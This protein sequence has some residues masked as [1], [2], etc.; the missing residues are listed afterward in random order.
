MKRIRITHLSENQRA[1]AAAMAHGGCEPEYPGVTRRTGNDRLPLSFPQERLWFLDQFQ[2]GVPV[3]NIV[4]Q[5]P[6]PGEPDSAAL[7]TSLRE[8]LRRHEALRTTF[9]VV[10]D[11][12]CQ[13]IRPVEDPCIAVD[14]LR[15]SPEHRRAA[16][17]QSLVDNEL[18]TP[19]DLERGPLYRLRLVRRSPARSL[20][21]V[22]VHHI[23]ADG[24]SV[25][26]FRRELEELYPL[27][28]SGRPSTLPELPA[29]YADFAL[30]Q[31][32]W[33][34]G[35]RLEKLLD[36]WRNQ[37]VGIPPLLGLP[38][39]FPRSNQQNFEGAA[40]SFVIPAPSVA[41]LED[42]ARSRR[43]TLF[44]ALLAVFD[45]LLYHYT[46]QD[47]VAV[48]TP[49]A[50]RP[51]REL[52][53]LIGFFAN[54]LVL[55]TRLDPR[56]PFLALI[57]RVRE[58]TLG[59]YAHQDLPFERVVEELQPE[60]RLSHNPLFQVMFVLQ[61]LPDLPVADGEPEQRAESSAPARSLAKFDLS[62]FLKSGADGLHGVVEYRTDLF[63]HERIA[64]LIEHFRRLIGRLT[65]RP[66]ARVADIDFLGPA[67]R[68]QLRGFQTLDEQRCEPCRGVEAMFAEQAA[69][70]LDAVAVEDADGGWSYRELAER[71]GRLASQLRSL[72]VGPESRVGVSVP[73]G[74]E[75]AVALLGILRAGGAYVPL[76]P[77]FPPERLALM[78]RDAGVA[79]HLTTTILRGSLPATPATVICLDV[80][81]SG[82]ALAVPPVPP[83]PDQLAYVIFTS[84][85]T[86][87]PKG[88]AVTHRVVSRLIA[89]QQRASAAAPGART[90]QF[91]HLGFDVSL[92]EM[93]ATLCTGG[94]LVFPGEETRR[95]MSALWE[96]IVD[97]RIE[98]LFT[99]PLV[100][101]ELAS[102][103]ATSSAGAPSLREI[104]AAGEALRITEPVRALARP[105]RLS[106][107]VNQYGPSETHVAT[108][109]ALSGDP[110]SWPDLPP[111]GKPIDG[112]RAYV[113]TPHG[114][115]SPIGIPG[116]LYL[117][118]ECV[119]RGYVDNP[120]ATAERFLPDPFGPPGTR[121]YRTGDVA[122]WR[123]DGALELFGRCDD[124][125]KIRGFRVEPGEV[126]AALRS[127]PQVRECAV[128]AAR[129]PSGD[130]FL[131]AY[132]VP[133]GEAPTTQ[134]LRRYLARRLPEYLLPS[135]TVV[136]DS[137]PRTPSGKVD[138]RRLP[139]P[140]RLQAARSETAHVPP[141]TPLECALA[142]IWSEVLQRDRVG[143][144][145]NFFDLGGHSLR[146]TQVVARVNSRLGLRMVVS[147]LFEAATVA[148]LAERL[149]PRAEPSEGLG[150]LDSA[151]RCRGHTAGGSS[152]E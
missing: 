51:R 46:G 83:H 16:A 40:Q 135:V 62:M 67:E 117:G 4:W 152:A 137:L 38:T 54:T 112:A 144:H 32:D 27:F 21:L 50:N 82:G 131:V 13:E 56:E 33:L 22:T 65:E 91:A 120:A 49:I 113:L 26:V 96:F 42:L 89:W 23:V 95:D 110:G 45:A 138:R 64:R 150:G 104:I 24:W 6:L 88:V 114:Q 105:A 128:A 103:S 87:R 70:A 81:W 74:R 48:G 101:R 71:A 90:L 146:A 61:N 118:G 30:W 57:D 115:L 39:D 52:E 140:E 107:L 59:A 12:P 9:R 108:A 97:R 75:V 124:Q 1:V 109:Y 17:L 35:E 73:R 78:S 53:D 122:R 2:P 111:V 36:Y 106:G 123:D 68:S 19:F 148:A 55:R 34:R 63:A 66:E 58:V 20:L 5:V 15:A 121:M 130:P 86:G 60:R 98:R 100:L 18:W 47:D 125:V 3:Y 142:A 134:E 149:A 136:V 43:A 80:P 141:Q 145:D 37:L 25:G 84:G 133:S 151:D 8:I 132:L 102:A 126:E 77:A 119:A 85:S 76:D 31:R 139:E 147:E 99:P 7:A 44:M 143:I 116:E 29:Q 28:A 94:T 69:C 93:L 10:D 72:G 129:P 92:Q 11:R 127:H 41:P 14:D 79:V